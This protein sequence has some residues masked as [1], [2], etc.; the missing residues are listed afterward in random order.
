MVDKYIM[1]TRTQL[2]KKKQHTSSPAPLSV[3]TSSPPPEVT[4]GLASNSTHSFWLI[5]HV[6]ACLFCSTSCES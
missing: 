6:A 5:Y 2:K 1:V 3:T 4:T